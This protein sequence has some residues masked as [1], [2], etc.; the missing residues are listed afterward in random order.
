ME[1]INVTDG[2]RLAIAETAQFKTAV[3]SLS[4]SVP[5]DHSAALNALLIRLLARTTKQYPTTLEMNRA[6]A[7]LYGATI[8][9]VIEKQGET[10]V[11]R[12]LL[13][14]LDDRFTIDNES[15]CEQCIRL[16]CD[17]FFAPDV[18]PDGFKKENIA[19]E[20]R[21]L[22]E[23]IDAERDDK[24]LYARQRLIEEMCKD[25]PYGLSKYGT[26]EEIEAIDGKMLF[27]Q[28]KKLLLHAPLEFGFV[29]STPKETLLPL[30]KERCVAFKKEGLLELHTE[31]LTESYGTKTLEETQKVNQ[32]K[33]VIGCRAGM[34]YDM[35]NY[36]AIRLMT[37]IF[38]GGTFSKLFMNVREKMSL[39]YYCSARLI[40]AKGI[41]LI[42]SGVE[43]EN[44]QKALAAIRA[45]L[46]DVRAGNFT[47]E[48]IEQ[49]KL[50]ICDALR[51]VSD[52]NSAM[53]GWFGSFTAA[54]RFYTPEQIADMIRSVSREE[55][56]LAA[57]MVTED[58]VFILKSEQEANMH[59]D[60]TH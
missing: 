58:T 21:L 15:V 37:A 51:G 38:G 49:A 33:L 23:K 25:E 52:S 5:L 35:D 1:L 42:E 44:A 34:T 27:E 55:I 48:V 4:V 50:S 31:F 60:E 53:L 17:C 9:P 19:L 46:D 29:G 18:T 13:S 28:W 54:E 11:L 41:I 16:L 2:V 45:E 3:M 30:L 59:A 22:I 12:L 7:T 20:K 36:A 56:I 24:I 26:K 8:S 32:G 10:Q 14:A 43:T 57:N 39:C 6:L 47:D 40:S